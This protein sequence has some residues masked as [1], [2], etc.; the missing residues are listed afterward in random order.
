MR[1]DPTRPPEADPTA[2]APCWRELMFG[3]IDGP[4]SAE[5]LEALIDHIEREPRPRPRPEERAR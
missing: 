3:V 2:I 5:R 4:F 1:R